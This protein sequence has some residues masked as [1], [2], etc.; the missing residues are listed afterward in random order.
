MSEEELK[1]EAM[2]ID[3]LLI[4]MFVSLLVM[5]AFSL[6]LLFGGKQVDYNGLSNNM[7]TSVIEEA[8]PVQ[9]Y[10]EGLE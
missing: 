1:R 3:A 8:E 7:D 10:V 2:I 4:T 9:I 6:F 5:L